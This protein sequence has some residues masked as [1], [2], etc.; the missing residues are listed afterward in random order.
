MKMVG[1]LPLKMYPFTFVN[2]QGTDSVKRIEG[3]C[4]VVQQVKECMCIPRLKTPLK[5]GNKSYCEGKKTI[6]I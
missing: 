5:S 6:E 3:C 1:L 4:T 2:A